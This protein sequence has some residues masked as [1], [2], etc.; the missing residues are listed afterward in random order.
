MVEL[1]NCLLE[2][3]QSITSADLGLVHD[4][5]IG[6]DLGQRHA[7]FIPTLLC[8]GANGIRLPLSLRHHF[9]NL[10]ATFI[11][12]HPAFVG[13]VIQIESSQTGNFA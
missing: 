2:T 6:I 7:L 4:A 11:Q 8:L 12:P 3:L 10:L 5:S 9:A 1:P 13:Q